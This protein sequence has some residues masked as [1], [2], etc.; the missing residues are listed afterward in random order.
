MSIDKVLDNYL[1]GPSVYYTRH[2]YMFIQILPP[3]V[4][5]RL[6]FFEQYRGHNYPDL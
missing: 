4:F 3:A 6:L 2:Y 1:V 5:F